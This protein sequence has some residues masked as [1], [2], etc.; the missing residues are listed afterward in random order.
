[1][2]EIRLTLHELAGADPEL[3]FSPHCWKTRMAL[4]HKGL[5]ARCLPW[6][7]TQK[8]RIA[9][10]GLDTV[11][12]LEDHETTIGNSWQ[13]AQHLEQSFP[14]H[15]SLFG[16]TAAVPLTAFINQWVDATLLPAMARILLLDIHRLLIP[17]DQVYFRASREARFGAT[18]ENIVAPVTDN[19]DRL[20]QLLAPLRRQ[21]RDQPYLCGAAPAYADY[22]IFGMFMWA[23]C[24][25][26][27]QL[28]AADDPIDAWRDRLLDAFGGMARS[29]ARPLLR[30]SGGDDG[31]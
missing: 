12:I 10:S 28:L 4:A 22:C 21:L 5:V 26:T 8:S 20:R 14:D 13:I 2:D 18:L 9:F 29:A 16:A 15:P 7:F 17:E 3:R 27:R 24:T 1:M 19:L 11:P 31:R 30:H 6:H 23:R 25:S